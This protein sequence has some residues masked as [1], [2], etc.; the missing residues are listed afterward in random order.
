M[1]FNSVGDLA[2]SFQMRHHNARLRSA[3]NRLTGE[4]ASGRRSD[5]ST[6]VK[7]DFGPLA[8]MNRS[9]TLLESYRSG[10]AE[11]AL[12]STAMQTALERIHDGVTQTAGP[13][14]AAGAQATGADL[15]IAGRD[16]RDTFEA[17]IAALNTSAAGQTLFAGRATDG[18]ALAPAVS[19][20]SD[21]QAL[22][23]GATSAASAASIVAAYFSSPG[24]G[25]VTTAY[26]GDAQAQSPLR[27]GDGIEVRVDITATRSELRDALAGLA[28]G[29]LLDG[30]LPALGTAERAALADTAGQALFGA[31]SGVAR[32]RG[33]LG[34]AQERIASAEVA[35]RAETSALE[36]ARS[37]ITDA[38]PYETA[39]A[40]ESVTVQLE[41]L[42]SLT[43]RVS[44]LSLTNY[45]R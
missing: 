42:L 11:A 33:E 1:S 40:L 29:A 26:L 23:A 19:I 12:R 39:T 14:A 31:G 30:G 36:I 24:G 17:A 13:L 3:L 37:R 27:V 35:N 21:L 28:M 20:L 41:T 45:L 2:Q 16:A 43:A 10:I 9:L 25:F 44:R 5:P 6:A 22:T 7:G 32:L 34:L 8:A 18:P 38:D 4:L 15:A